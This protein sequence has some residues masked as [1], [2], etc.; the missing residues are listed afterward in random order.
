ML[1]VSGVLPVLVI[2][3]VML[4]TGVVVFTPTC[5]Y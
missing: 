5:A 1:R 3:L 2:M 4:T